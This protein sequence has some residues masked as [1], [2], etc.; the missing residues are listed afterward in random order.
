MSYRMASRGV[1]ELATGSLIVPGMW[2]WY[3]YEDWLAAGHVPEPRLI[4]QSELD[5]AAEATARAAMR[6]TLKADATITYLRTHTPLEAAAYA[7]SNITDLASAKVVI[8]KLTMV[9][10]YLARD[11]LNQ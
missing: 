3:A 6:A 1:I 4:P 5:E 8:G 9:V 11:R 10:A 2:Q 7:A